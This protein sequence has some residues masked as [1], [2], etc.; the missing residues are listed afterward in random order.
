LVPALQLLAL[1]SNID[2]RYYAPFKSYVDPNLTS[3]QKANIKANECKN[4]KFAG[5]SRAKVKT[6]IVSGN[7]YTYSTLLKFINT[8]PPDVD[9][10]DVIDALDKPW[11]DRAIQEL[12]NATLTNVYLKAYKR[13]EDNDYHLIVT[14]ASQT[15]FFNVE[16]SALPGTTAAS[17]QTLKT[18]RNTFE[19]FLSKGCGG[20]YAMF[21][22]PMKII[23]LNGSIFFDTDHAG[24]TV[25]PSGFR[26]K[27]AW[28]IHP[29]TFIEFE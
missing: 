23:K 15:L 20:S 11:K 14:D 7:S 16:I 28:E 2:Y 4:A 25:G 27:K 13:E 21:D 1:V 29:V 18:V 9:M 6:S 19:A 5:L 8:L 24:G 10:E 17:Y 12:K 3:T 26:P 22:P